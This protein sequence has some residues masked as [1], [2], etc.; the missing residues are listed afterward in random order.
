MK[1][2]YVVELKV[3]SEKLIY[4]SICVMFYILGI[5]GKFKGVVLSN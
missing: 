4:D 1:F 3:C 2:K 5:I